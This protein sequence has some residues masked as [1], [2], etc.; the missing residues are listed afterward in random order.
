MRTRQSQV[1]SPSPPHAQH[2]HL[3]P[4]HQLPLCSLH[5]LGIT[6]PVLPG[7]FRRL[8][9]MLI[10]RTLCKGTRPSLPFLSPRPFSSHSGRDEGRQTCFSWGTH[11]GCLTTAAPSST[12]A[13]GGSALQDVCKNDVCL[14]LFFPT[15]RRLPCRDTPLAT[16]VTSFPPPTTVS[17]LCTL[18]P[19]SHW[20]QT[21]PR[22]HLCVG[23]TTVLVP[24]D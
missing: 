19:R 12:F 23:P 7:H 15:H 4:A 3:Q 21:S 9:P 13:P 6:T 1:S 11:A 10:L 14:F 24:R 20:E 18:V 22:S 8:P 2:L 17:G 5:L 16:L